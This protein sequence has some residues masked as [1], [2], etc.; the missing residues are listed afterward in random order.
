[1]IFKKIIQRLVKK[2]GLKGLIYK[3]GDFAVSCTKD[4]KDD[5]LWAKVKKVLDAV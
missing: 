2:H 4:K 3:V 5:Q 1:M